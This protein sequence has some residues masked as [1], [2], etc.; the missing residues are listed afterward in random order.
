M[1]AVSKIKIIIGAAASAGLVATAAAFYTS[2]SASVPV[3]DRPAEQQATLPAGLLA[4]VKY[5][6]REWTLACGKVMLVVFMNMFAVLQL[7]SRQSDG[8][9][10]PSLYGWA[11]D[12]HSRMSGALEDVGGTNI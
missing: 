10:P 1:P 5:K 4:P 11:A 3:E 9:F 7:P 6:V 12:V 8:S 2:G